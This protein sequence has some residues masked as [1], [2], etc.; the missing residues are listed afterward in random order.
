M[1]ALIIVCL[2]W[3]LWGWTT[4][5]STVFLQNLSSAPVWIFVNGASLGQV[6][7]GAT[8]QALREGFQTAAGQVGGWGDARGS[9]NGE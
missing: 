6:R 9:A 2:L 7:A 8:Q 5:V 4:E 3:P 1:R